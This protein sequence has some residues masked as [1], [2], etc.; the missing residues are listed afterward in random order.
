MDITKTD[1]GS[2]HVT[3]PGEPRSTN[4]PSGP[5]AGQTP[6][7]PREQPSPSVGCGKTILVVDDETIIRDITRALLEANGYQVLTASDGMEA[8]AVFAQ[9]GKE[10]S[11]AI[12][13]LMMP[14]MDGMTTVRTLR[15]MNPAL[16]IIVMSGMSDEIMEIETDGEPKVVFL[17]KPFS[18]ETL[19]ARMREVLASV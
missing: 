18:G 10:I 13:D 3:F 2:G 4:C 11:L 12:T 19:L 16:K 9:S 8:V 15:K 5:E 1:G 7:I 17:L 14:L 6:V